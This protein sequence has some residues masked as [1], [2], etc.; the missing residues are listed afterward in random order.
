[1]SA[2]PSPYHEMTSSYPTPVPTPASGFHDDGAVGHSRHNGVIQATVG[3]E[4]PSSFLFPADSIAA[5]KSAQWQRRHDT[6]K[7]HDDSGDYKISY[8]YPEALEYESSVQR[9]SSEYAWGYT[10]AHPET[11]DLDSHH[12]HRRVMTESPVSAHDDR[13]SHA[14]Y[15]YRPLRSLAHSPSAFSDYNTECHQTAKPFYGVSH[16]YQEHDFKQRIWETSEATTPVTSAAAFETRRYT[17]MPSPAHSQGHP[18]SPRA[19]K[20]MEEQLSVPRTLPLSPASVPE[21]MVQP[22]LQRS[23]SEMQSQDHGSAYNPD[24]LPAT[25]DFTRTYNPAYTTRNSTIEAHPS[26][27]PEVLT[28]SSII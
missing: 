18:S 23:S 16:Q 7:Q 26:P 9:K 2:M 12:D 11:M 3:R 13:T 19:T 22:S 15:N 21:I 4:S 20:T 14:A 25:M 24:A 1:M 5:I 28:K 17:S 27:H 10:H 8:S 6:H